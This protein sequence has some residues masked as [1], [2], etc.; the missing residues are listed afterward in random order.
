MLSCVNLERRSHTST[1]F[2]KTP[3]LVPRGR[4]TKNELVGKKVTPQKAVISN[5]IFDDKKQKKKNKTTKNDMDDSP[6]IDT[7]L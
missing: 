7:A 1:Q 5:S 3:T 2:L 4:K 6:C